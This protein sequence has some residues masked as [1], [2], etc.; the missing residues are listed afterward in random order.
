MRLVVEVQFVHAFAEDKHGK[1][2][3]YFTTIEDLKPGDMVVVDSQPGLG[4]AQVV[5]YTGSNL[6]ASRWVVQRIDMGSHVA[7][8]E[9]LNQIESIQ[10]KIMARKAAIEE[11]AILKMLAEKDDGIAG[12]LEELN[13]LTRKL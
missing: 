11:E 8:M 13:D 10:R 6:K 4:V 7:R 1:T 9:K 5:D 2:Y 3:H 12:L